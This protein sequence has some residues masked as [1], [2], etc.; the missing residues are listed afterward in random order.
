MH[1]SLS[2]LPPC[3]WGMTSSCWCPLPTP[4]CKLTW[5]WQFVSATKS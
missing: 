2:W 1:S 5:S 4:F 3:C